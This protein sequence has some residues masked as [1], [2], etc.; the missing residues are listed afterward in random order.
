MN[1]KLAI[2]KIMRTIRLCLLLSFFAFSALL[3]AG[4]SLPDIDAKGVKIKISE[5]FEAHAQYKKMEPVL[6]KRTLKEYINDLDPT[7]T[8]F[9]E[10]EIVKWT[11][12]SEWAC[13]RSHFK[14]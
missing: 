13:I 2:V 9:Y 11:C 6:I 10:S 4:Q 7:K 12:Q 8:Y 14:S 1:R 3:I 5:I